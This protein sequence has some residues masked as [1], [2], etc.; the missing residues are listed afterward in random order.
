MIL[1]PEVR[2]RVLERLGFEREPAIDFE[3]LSA[4]YRAWGEVV[5][6][7]NSAKLIALKT[8][9][10]GR[11]PLI[12]AGEFFTNF[13]A[14]G[15]GGTCWP[16]SNAIYSLL[17]DVG[18]DA[19]R[20]AGSMRDTGI[21]SH[22]STSVRLDGADWLVDSSMLTMNPLPLGDELFVA[23]SLWNAEVEHVDGTHVIWWD[24]TPSPKHIPCRLLERDVSH[25]VYVERFEASRLR[26]PFN[27][28]LYVRR[29]R[30]DGVLVITGNRRYLRTANGTGTGTLSEKELEESLREEAG[31]SSRLIEMLRD[32]GAIRDSMMPASS[33]PPPLP[34]LRPSLRER[35]S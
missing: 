35:Q 26:S 12:D 21:L 1:D 23:D 34:G 2:A 10:P 33:S 5:A 13:L 30:A 22:G 7:D 15:S 16:S 25:D 9:A 4:L 24:A 27:E 20:L 31:F 17:I 19:N 29:N 3:G 8:G 28:R 32:C 14:H 6:F 11:L 18:F